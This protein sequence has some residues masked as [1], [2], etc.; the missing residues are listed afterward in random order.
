METVTASSPDDLGAVVLADLKTQLAR[1]ASYTSEIGLLREGAASA[2]HVAGNVLR[3]VDQL[4]DLQRSQ[5]SELRAVSDT[6]LG[7]HREALAGVADAWGRQW[8]QEATKSLAVLDTI[9]A[10]QHVLASEIT[11]FQE[12]MRNAATFADAQLALRTQ[13]LELGEAMRQDLADR[14]SSHGQFMD[15]VEQE[16]G[17]L[18]TELQRAASAQGEAVVGLASVVREGADTSANASTLLGT[19]LSELE[20][21]LREFGGQQGKDMQH[22]AQQTAA[23]RNEQESLRLQLA[24][25]SKAQ[26]THQDDA[27]KA[28]LAGQ[29]GSRRWH[30]ATIV[31]VVVTLLLVEL[32]R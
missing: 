7:A 30:V 3:L 12:A 6:T 17:A 18:K 27:R 21:T 2:V 4:E 11:E 23:L 31:V 26:A 13:V 8:L 22:L 5:I 25:Q 20:A 32:L 1:L 15:L 16:C 10:R 28:V 29:S 9:V 24:E 14:A 19:R